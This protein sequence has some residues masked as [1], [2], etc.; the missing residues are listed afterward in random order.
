M[1][2]SNALD[3]ILAQA[4]QM[5]QRPVR[6]DRQLFEVEA[7]N[8]LQVLERIGP[9]LEREANPAASGQLQNMCSALGVIIISMM[10]YARGLN[11]QVASKKPNANIVVQ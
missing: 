10:A 4:L 7:S 8:L 9:H 5:E 1:K 6:R 2:P 3:P 11:P